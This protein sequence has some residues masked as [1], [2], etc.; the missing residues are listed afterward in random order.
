MVIESIRNTVL[1]INRILDEHKIK[2]H[3]TLYPSGELKLMMKGHSAPLLKYAC[4]DKSTKLEKLITK[5]NTKQLYEIINKAILFE[6][7]HCDN[8]SP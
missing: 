7:Q 5:Y 3:V 2:V 6:T 4:D 1:T 8:K